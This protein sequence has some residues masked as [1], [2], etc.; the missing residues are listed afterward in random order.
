MSSVVLPGSL[1]SVL[2][3]ISVFEMTESEERE[4]PLPAM[5]ALTSKFFDGFDFEFSAVLCLLT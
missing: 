2:G 5:N 4:F 1:S 3:S